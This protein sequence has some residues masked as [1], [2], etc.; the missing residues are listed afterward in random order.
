MPVVGTFDFT[1]E[2]RRAFTALPAPA[3]EAFEELLGGRVGEDHPIG[4]HL[5]RLLLEGVVYELGGFVDEAD[6]GGDG[7]ATYWVLSAGPRGQG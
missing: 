5:E 2:G 7:R 3:Q 1:A 4:V 6:P